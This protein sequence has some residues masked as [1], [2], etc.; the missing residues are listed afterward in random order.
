MADT[1][2]SKDDFVNAATGLFKNNVA[3]D[4]SPQDLRDFVESQHPPYGSMYWSTAIETSISTV[5]T[6]T[7]AAG[8][9][10]SVSLRHFDMPASNR[11]RY[12]GTP[13]IHVHGVVSLSTNTASAN[14]TLRTGAYHYDDSGASGSVLTHSVLERRHASND[15]GAIA[16]HFDAMLETND[17]IELHVKNI[18]DSTNMTVDYGYMFMLGMFM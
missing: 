2:R 16:I 5:D 4:I 15:I 6:W 9:T 11:L 14:K 7:K 1:R 3:K 12:T 17:Y 18:T 13:S 8:T 10:S